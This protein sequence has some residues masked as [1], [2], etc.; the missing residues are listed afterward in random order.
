MDWAKSI[1]AFDFEE[2]IRIYWER[3]PQAYV[4]S[5]FIAFGINAVVFSYLMVHFPAGNH[6]WGYLV[7][8]FNNTEKDLGRWVPVLIDALF[9]RMRL[10]IV[11]YLF[12]MAVQVMAGLVAYSYLGRV[13]KVLPITLFALFVSLIPYVCTYYYYSAIT[14]M[15]AVGTLFAAL[16]VL[17]ASK[18]H[19]SLK[20]YILAVAFAFLTPSAYQPQMNAVSALFVL[21]MLVTLCDAIGEKTYNLRA[22]IMSTIIK[23]SAIAAGSFL[24]FVFVKLYVRADTATRYQFEAVQ[25]KDF[26]SNAVAV[27]KSSF[28]LLMQTQEL[29]PEPLRIG[30][31][32][33]LILTIVLLLQKVRCA[34]LSSK[35]KA[36]HY[37]VVLFLFGLAVISSKIICF[38]FE[39]LSHFSFRLQGGVIFL[40]A[41]PAALLFRSRVAVVRSFSLI[42]MVICLVWCIQQ[43][44]LYQVLAVEEQKY[45]YQ[46][47][48]DIAFKIEGNPQ[49]DTQ[50]EYRYVQLG[51]LRSVKRLI[52]E[53]RYRRGL[54][55]KLVAGDQIFGPIQLLR[56][57]LIKR[58]MPAAHFS[59]T[60]D[61]ISF[62]IEDLKEIVQYAKTHRPWPASEGVAILRDDIVLVYLD[63][64]PIDKLEQVIKKGRISTP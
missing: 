57:E 16:C 43:D 49:F 54:T 44:I 25:A 56:G 39:N 2:K 5:F 50:K 52:F 62:P 23:A 7:W 59:L 24:Y 46:A 30:L 4:K 48:S 55:P 33:L 17:F 61:Y 21:C 36:V 32:V 45:A 31:G 1:M 8:I 42:A 6:D 3:I 27:I 64:T 10:P 28:G 51:N 19:S 15:F 63:D 14:P 12:T 22:F 29:F 38:Y 58:L 35:S 9:G 47:G 34:K 37:F 40:Y 18:A 13:K 26:F 60:W 20:S 11:T 41:L 53:K